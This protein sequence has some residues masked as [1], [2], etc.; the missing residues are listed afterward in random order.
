MPAQLPAAPGAASGT[1]AVA[2]SEP[3]PSGDEDDDEGDRKGFGGRRYR[4]EMLGRDSFADRFDDYQ[5][6]LTL[7]P[8]SPE[9]PA[10]RVLLASLS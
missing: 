5:A 7:Q 6:F 2:E 9:A 3:D 4:T 8:E 1:G 10:L